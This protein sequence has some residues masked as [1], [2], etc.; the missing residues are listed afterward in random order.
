MVPVRPLLQHKSLLRA[1]DEATHHNAAKKGSCRRAAPH[2]SAPAVHIRCSIIT[3]TGV[4]FVTL[5]VTGV[6]FVHIR[7]YRCCI[8]S[9]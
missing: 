3:V 1:A 8:R 9:H 7:C 4:V 5:G 6:V 2:P